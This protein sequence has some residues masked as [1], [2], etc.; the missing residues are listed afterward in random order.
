MLLGAAVLVW[1]FLGR[2]LGAACCVALVWAGGGAAGESL[3]L[4]QVG[5]LLV[6]LLAITFTTC[7]TSRGIAT[8]VGA[9]VKIL[10]GVL[11]LPLALAREWRALIAGITA[12]ALLILLPMLALQG[13]DGPKSPAYAAF[14]LGS[15]TITNWSVPST[16]LRVLDPPASHGALPANWEFGNQGTSL[17][18][19]ESQRMASA[20]ASLFVFIAG[21]MLLVWRT[22]SLQANPLREE[23]LPAAMAGWLSLAL[24]AAPLCWSHYQILQYPGVAL[25]LGLAMAHRRWKL[26]AATVACAALL[27]PVPV[28]VLTAYY[29]HYGWTAASPWQLYVWTSATPAACLGLFGLSLKLAGLGKKVHCAIGQG[30]AS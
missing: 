12:A 28:A 22:R 5:P 20:A 23:H 16:V 19:P 6:L 10:P 7:G 25:L 1:R 3:A 14:L 29:H 21:A 17:H 11:A 9:A 18:L 24:A 30:P 4:G 8:G 26:A 27:Y 13:F 15:P 2:G